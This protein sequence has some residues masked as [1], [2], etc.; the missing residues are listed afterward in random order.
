MTPQDVPAVMEIEFEAFSAPWSAR[1]YD[2]E[3]HYNEMAHYYVVRPEQEVVA[4]AV[5]ERQ[6]LLKRLLGREKSIGMIEASTHPLV[7]YGGFW[8]MVDEAHVSTIATHADWRRRG[9]GE[10]LLVTMIDGAMQVGARWVTLE[11]RVSNTGAQALYRKYGF[12]IT[13]VRKRYYS[14]NNEDA[15]IMTTPL[16]TTIEYQLKLQGLKG[17]LFNR[18]AK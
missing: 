10:L 12:D 17:V 8:L 13:G 5:V 1:A 4:P 3:L 6:S 9:I 2:Y 14:D 16:I 7:G 15:V 18:L 11:A